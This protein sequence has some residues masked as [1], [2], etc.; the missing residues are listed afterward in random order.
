[1]TEPAEGRFSDGAVTCGIWC[2]ASP[3]HPLLTS[4]LNRNA[5]RRAAQVALEQDR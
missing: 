1:M 5:E 3:D 2:E 4:S